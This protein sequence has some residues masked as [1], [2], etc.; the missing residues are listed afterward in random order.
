ML[1]ASP[2]NNI[3]WLYFITRVM[4]TEHVL[5][6]LF[7]L[8]FTIKKWFYSLYFVG[9]N[10]TCIYIL[11]FYFYAFIFLDPKLNILKAHRQSFCQSSTIISCLNEA[12]LKQIPWE[13][14]LSSVL[15]LCIFKTIFHSF[16]T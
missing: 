16:D 7:S 8:L 2:L 15:T 12:L 5:L 14:F 1:P 11:F 13:A 9:T 10:N 4:T 3:L 6:S